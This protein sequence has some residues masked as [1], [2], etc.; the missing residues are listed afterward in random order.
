MSGS[1]NSTTEEVLRSILAVLERM[2][3]MFQGQQKQIDALQNARDIG[4]TSTNEAYEAAV[5]TRLPE[6]SLDGVSGGGGEP[7]DFLGT[8]EA[9]EAAVNTELPKSSS[10]EENGREAEAG[11]SPEASETVDL[12]A[13]SVPDTD[14]LAEHSTPIMAAASCQLGDIPDFKKLIGPA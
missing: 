2:E 1:G 13:E 14:N 11:N 12:A 8:D 4:G 6:S 3:K 7:T 10:D 9:H 5:D